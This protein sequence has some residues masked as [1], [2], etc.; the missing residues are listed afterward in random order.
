MLLFKVIAWSVLIH[1]GSVLFVFGSIITVF[2]TL[3]VLFG[4][5]SR[6]ISLLACSGSWVCRLINIILSESLGLAV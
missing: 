2:G 3:F 4:S 6:I 5:F 1:F